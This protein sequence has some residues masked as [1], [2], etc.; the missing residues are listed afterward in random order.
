MD[1][2]PAASSSCN[3]IY[4]TVIWCF[5]GGTNLCS[6]EIHLS[7]NRL[8]VW[9]TFQILQSLGETPLKLQTTSL[10][11][12]FLTSTG[13]LTVFTYTNENKYVPRLAV[14]RI[15]QVF[16]HLVSVSLRP[17]KTPSAKGL[18]LSACRLSFLM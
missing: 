3:K 11:T 12:P 10:F 7:Q 14:P 1:F 15:C 18:T 13:T 16:L 9:I 8:D 6:G 2:F 5:D 4:I 17:T